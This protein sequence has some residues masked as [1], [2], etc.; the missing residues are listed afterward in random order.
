M[1]KKPISDVK[2]KSATVAPEVLSPQS[3]KGTGSSISTAASASKLRN[4]LYHTSYRPSH[5]ATFIGLAVVAVILGINVAVIMLLMKNDG[6]S[7]DN[8]NQNEV[9]ISADVLNGLGV[10]NSGS[11]KGSLLTVNPDASFKGNLTI[12]GDASVSG[13]LNLNNKITATDASITK[14]EAGQTT[15][16]DLN[17]NGDVT[18]SNLN[19]R[20]NLIVA[21]TSTMQGAVTMGQLLTVNNNVNI[22]GSLSVGGTLSTR[23]F[24]AGSLVSDT[25]LTIGGHVITRGSAPSYSRGSNLR[26]TD[27]ISMSGNDASG[28]VILNVG[29]GSIG[30]GCFVAASFVNAYSNIPHIVV[31]PVGPARDVYTFRSATGFSICIASSLS[32]G[33]YAFDYI[34]MQ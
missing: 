9:T 26:D 2:V 1:E 28:T 7:S 11:S 33:G 8:L 4:R 15:L 16:Q 21:G 24:Q 13:K 10:N 12:A 32:Y 34:V 30:T 14:L 31:T 22:S 23:G 27:T 29:A 18:V 5:K 6:S 25:T 3:A 17:V 19:T 20:T